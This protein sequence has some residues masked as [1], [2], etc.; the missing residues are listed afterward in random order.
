MRTFMKKDLLL[1]WRNRRETAIGLLLPLLLI[2]VLN[3]I[4]AD[5]QTLESRPSALTLA[6]V[7][8]DGR[9]PEAGQLLD[10]LR[11]PA[12]AEW[13]TVA[14]MPKPEALRQVESGDVDGLLVIPAGF[15]ERLGRADVREGE[16]PARLPLIVKEYSTNAAAL[17][18]VVRELADQMNFGLALSSAAD[19]RTPDAA[20]LPQAGSRETIEGA[21]PFTMAQYFTIAIGALF[22]LF[23]A[24]SVGERT[25][26]EK[27][28]QVVNRVILSGS[29]PLHFLMGKTAAA[30]CLIWLQFA[31]V[32]IVSH[33]N[34]GVF[35][36]KQ[37][38]FWLG[39][40]VMITVYAAA[41]AGLAALYT[42]ITLRMQSLDAV[43]GLFMMVTIVFG[44]IGGG[45][46][47]IQLF[48]EWLQR[49]G[50]WTPNGRTLAM[51]AE[52][53]QFEDWSVQ[54]ASLAGMIAFTA[55]VLT[56]GIKLFPRRGVM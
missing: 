8:E 36:G 49:I 5:L 48:P 26:A 53:I 35:A 29:R 11:S 38:Q 12:L 47:P 24:A 13:L 7:N 16:E 6:V 1:S 20:M 28:E 31:F 14:E 22:G 39:L 10:G 30:F 54:W 18:E 34:L 46:A 52:W 44:T 21:Q 3:Y 4:F 42:A 2:L 50:E 19:G 56:A 23:I 15:S 45:F 32:V 40:L 33:L 17:G 51:A 25:A 43:N 55:V 9:S 41:L 27:R 37:L